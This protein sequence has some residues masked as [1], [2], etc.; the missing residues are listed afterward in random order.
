MDVIIQ[1][2][3]PITPELV[4]T[5]PTD[6]IEIEKNKLDKIEAYHQPVGGYFYTNTI[7]YNEDIIPSSSVIRLIYPSNT[8]LSSS[9]QYSNSYL[10]P[11]TLIHPE[12]K[13]KEDVFPMKL[14]TNKNKESVSVNKVADF[15]TVLLNKKEIAKG[16]LLIYSNPWV[17]VTNGES[18]KKI[19]FWQYT[20]LNTDTNKSFTL[21]L[22]GKIDSIEQMYQGLFFKVIEQSFFKTTSWIY[23]PSKGAILQI[24]EAHTNIVA[25]G[26]TPWI[27]F[28]DW[29][30]NIG[31]VFRYDLWREVGGI[32][33][34][35]YQVRSIN[36]YQDINKKWNLWIIPTCTY[37]K[38]TSNV[39]WMPLMVSRPVITNMDFHKE[40]YVTKIDLDDQGHLFMYVHEKV[41]TD[42]STNG[43]NSFLLLTQKQNKSTLIPLKM[44]SSVNITRMNFGKSEDKTSNGDFIFSAE[45]TEQSLQPVTCKINPLTDEIMKKKFDE[46][47]RYFDSYIHDYISYTPL[48]S[49]KDI[50]SPIKNG[51]VSEKDGTITWKQNITYIATREYKIPIGKLVPKK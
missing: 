19:K 21:S 20:L 3:E 26:E 33:F 27:V 14:F 25:V 42:K 15:Y 5:S 22:P 23:N 51:T 24:G 39:F 7:Q 41:G 40:F 11:A 18:D 32:D 13:D 34:G 28:W 2:Y 6:P 47:Y 9:D 17:M 48:A 44:D 16:K 4:K 29:Y 12:S 8:N 31:K 10:N 46:R 49:D 43:L 50:F 45:K 30:E 36:P 1:N 35:K 38:F 37:E